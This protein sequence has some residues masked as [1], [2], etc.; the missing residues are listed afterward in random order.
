MVTTDIQSVLDRSASIGWVL[1]PEAKTL[2]KQAGIGVPEFRW[3]KTRDEAR[4]AAVELGYPL[5]AKIVSPKI[6]HK[7]DVG[8]VVLGIDCD[9]LLESVVDRFSRFEQYAGVHLERMSKGVE[10]I[11]GAKIDYQFGPVILLG[12]GGT[13]VEIYQDAA[14]RMAP[15]SGD[16]VM[17]MVAQLKARRLLEGYRGQAPVDMNRLTRTVIAFADLVMRI[18]DRIE[19]I[20]I[21]PLMCT[22]DSCLAADARIM[23]A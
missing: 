4:A 18:A 22:A 8:G 5:A 9:G 23:L 13:G 15:L 12:I 3:V 16:D 2:F 17:D 7:S 14:I 6:V 10:L 20:D 1:E 11:L 21:N 19:S